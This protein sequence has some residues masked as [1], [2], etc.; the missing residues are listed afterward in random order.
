M[1]VVLSKKVIDMYI[2]L[3]EDCKR[4]NNQKCAI[5]S[6]ALHEASHQRKKRILYTPEILSLTFC[7]YG[8]RR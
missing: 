3:D 4:D 1:S 2:I 5:M 7:Q 6:I 8:S